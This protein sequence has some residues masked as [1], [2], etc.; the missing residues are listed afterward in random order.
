MQTWL[1]C[2]RKG[3]KAIDLFNNPVI[4][5]ITGFERDIRTQGR[6]AKKQERSLKQSITWGL[7]HINAWI[8]QSSW[9]NVLPLAD[10]GFTLTKR[11]FRDALNLRYNKQLRSLPSNCPCGQKFNVIHALNCK[12]GDFVTMRHS[13]IRGFEGNL[14]RIVHK[15]VEVEPQLQQVD[16][17]Q[18]NGP[19]ED[20][21]PPDIRIKGVWTNARNAYFDVRVTNVSS[22]SQKNMPV[23]KILSKH[24]E[25]KKRNYNRRIINVEHGIFTPLF[26]SVTDGEGTETSTFHHHLASKI[27]LKKD[28]R[29]EDVVIFIRCKLLFLILRSTVTCIQGSRPYDKDSVMVNDFSLTCDSAGI[30]WVGE[31][32]HTQALF[33]YYVRSASHSR[34]F[35]TFCFHSRFAS[36]CWYLPYFLKLFLTHWFHIYI[37]CFITSNLTVFINFKFYS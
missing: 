16:N 36:E 30:R 5:K 23:E 3:F 32:L 2:F 34:F 18:F 10:Y 4:R 26:F 27:A 20:N 6:S 28:E 19:K 31:T 14:S 7:K 15:D 21:A 11:E 25:G 13:N 17:E 1:S 9:L 37:L 33:F 12:K 35:H 24:E 29:Y 8:K 22:D